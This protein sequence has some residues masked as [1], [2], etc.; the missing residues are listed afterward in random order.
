[1]SIRIATTCD[2]RKE[3]IEL[4]ERCELESLVN[5]GEIL[6]DDGVILHITGDFIEIETFNDEDLDDDDDDD[7]NDCDYDDDVYDFF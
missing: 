7:D 3:L 2:F 5:Y 4:I 6:F 1:M